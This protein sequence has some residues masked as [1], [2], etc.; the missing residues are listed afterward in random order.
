MPP[1][2]RAPVCAPHECGDRLEAQTAEFLHQPERR[3][4]A[5]PGRMGRLGR[6]V[7][8]GTRGADAQ[9]LYGWVR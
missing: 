3:V 2:D 8:L 6:P 7:S 4:L 9:S 5:M 1:A